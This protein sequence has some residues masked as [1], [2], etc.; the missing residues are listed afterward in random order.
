MSRGA[1][2]T[3]RITGKVGIAD[4]AAW[5]ICASLSVAPNPPVAIA[6]V[7][8]RSMYW[9]RILSRLCD[10]SCEHLRRGMNSD[11]KS[12]HLLPLEAF[13]G[14]PIASW[15]AATTYRGPATPASQAEPPQDRQSS[16]L[17]T[18]LAAVL[19]AVVEGLECDGADFYTLDEA[20][21]CLELRVTH[22]LAD[23]QPGTPQRPLSKALADVAA[24]AGSAIVLEDEAAM[25]DWPVP[26]WCGAAVCLPV[27]S[28]RTVYGSLWLYHSK[29][30]AFT[31]SQVEMAEVVAGRLAVELEVEKLRRHL[32]GSLSNRTSRYSPRQPKTIPL[33]P[34]T[35]RPLGRSEEEW[36]MAGWLAPAATGNSFYDWH[37]LTDGRMLVVAGA[38]CQRPEGTVSLLE[39]ARIALRSLA[40]QSYDAGELLT[41]VNRTLWSAS[42]EGGG[43]SLAVALVDGE[44]AHASVALSGSSAA[45]SWRASTCEVIP[46]TCAP[47]GWSEQSIYVPRRMEV[48][49]RQRLVLTATGAKLTSTTPLDGL[50]KVLRRESTDAVRTMS[51]KRAM[52]LVARTIDRLGSPVDSLTLIRRP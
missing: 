35:S 37:S 33:S 39:S 25:A 3:G 12:A 44:E 7:N 9:L 11:I 22:H 43:L 46:A 49:V 48:L 26:V 41:T 36:D 32:G 27:A 51:A 2:S 19:R 47:V 45:L 13:A 30:R 1:P 10:S 42:P 16:Q 40:S 23:R 5:E 24:M 4:S 38:A 29:S 18:R 52:R 20:T 28:D 34:L 14:H 17:N 21:T 8:L 50:A 31:D 6:E 15:P